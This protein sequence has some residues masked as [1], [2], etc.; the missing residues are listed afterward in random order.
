[1]ALADNWTAQFSIKKG[2]KCFFKSDLKDFFGFVSGFTASTETTN[3]L[4]VNRLRI[5]VCSLTLFDDGTGGWSRLRRR[6]DHVNDALE[7]LGQISKRETLAEG[8]KSLVCSR[9]K[10]IAQSFQMLLFARLV[11]L[12]VLAQVFQTIATVLR[13]LRMKSMLHT[14]NGISTFVNT[15]T[16][17]ARIFDMMA[18]LWHFRYLLLE[19]PLSFWSFSAQ[20]NTSSFR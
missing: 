10:G 8:S 2:K 11:M 14:C 16:I 12:E 6:F 7:L 20:A 9:S 19:T 15:Q 5:E 3:G 1:M 17:W 18:V 4:K 13:V